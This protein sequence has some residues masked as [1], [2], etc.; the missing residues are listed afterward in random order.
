[1]HGPLR[2]RGY[3]CNLNRFMSA[4]H[5]GSSLRKRWTAPLFLYEYVAAQMGVL[6]NRKAE[7]YAQERAYG[8][9]PRAAARAAGYADG[10]GQP[11]KIGQRMSLVTL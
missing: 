10:S 7:A 9:P 1:L 8:I 6:K 11:T 5:E 2:K 4:V 3:K